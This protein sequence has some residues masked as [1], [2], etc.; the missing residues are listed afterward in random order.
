[1]YSIREQGPTPPDIAAE[2]HRRRGH[3][4]AGGSL[5]VGDGSGG[6]EVAR[7]TRLWARHWRRG[8]GGYPSIA[9]QPD[10]GSSPQWRAIARTTRQGKEN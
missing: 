10:D 5:G 3:G 4:H 1:M 2:L 6:F 8:T 9:E 7:W